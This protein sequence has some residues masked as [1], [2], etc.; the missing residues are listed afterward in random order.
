MKIFIS[1]PMRNKSNEEIEDVRR[2]I[3]DKAAK[4]FPDE[5]VIEI[6][7]YFGNHAMKDLEALGLSIQM[8]QNAKMVYF[9]PGWEAARGCRIEHEVAE[10]YGKDF[11]DLTE[12]EL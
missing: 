9:A 1:Q 4:D 2:K 10:M 6:A 3:M 5:T 8:M 7:S 11:T 12:D